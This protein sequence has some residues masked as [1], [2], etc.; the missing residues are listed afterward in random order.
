[1]DIVDCYSKLQKIGFPIQI[2]GDAN[3]V[4]INGLAMLAVNSKG[5]HIGVD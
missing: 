2:A 5:N 1:M 3:F 4:T